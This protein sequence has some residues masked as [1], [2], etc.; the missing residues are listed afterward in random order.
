M[1]A[2]TEPPGCGVRAPSYEAERTLP[3]SRR[4]PAPGKFGLR[5]V[6]PYLAAWAGLFGLL[7]PP[8]AHAAAGDTI[9]N[10]FSIEFSSNGS[11]TRLTVQSNRVDTVVA[12]LPTWRWTPRTGDT[13]SR[14]GDT[15]V[16]P[17]VLENGGNGQ[18]TAVFQFDTTSFSVAL[19]A[20]SALATPL[21][22]AP[23]A[24]GEARAVYVAISLPGGAPDGTS[25]TDAVG[26]VSTADPDTGSDTLSIRVTADAAPPSAPTGL[27][28]ADGETVTGTSVTF[29]WNAASDSISGVRDYRVEVATDTTFTTLL[30]DSFVTTTSLNLSLAPGR[31]AWRVRARD[32][33][34]FFSTVAETPVFEVPVPGA[35]ETLKML[36]VRP[37]FVGS[38]TT[39]LVVSLLTETGAL[40]P[41]SGD[42]VILR[43]LSSDSAPWPDSPVVATTSGGTAAFDYGD[44]ADTLLEFAI[45]VARITGE[46][47]EFPVVYAW[48]DAATNDP[49]LSYNGDSMTAVLVRES[50]LS[51]TWRIVIRQVPAALTGLV[52]RANENLAGSGLKPLAG[53]GFRPER[54]VFV[55]DAQGKRI[56]WLDTPV[57]IVLGYPESTP[58]DGTTDLGNLKESTLR[59][60]VLDEA[61]ERWTP[62]PTSRLVE[63]KARLEAERRNFSIFTILGF[64]AGDALEG[65]ISYPNPFYPDLSGG[66]VRGGVAQPG[67]VTIDLRQSVRSMRVTIYNLAGDRVRTLANPTRTAGVP[68]VDPT[69]GLA[70]WDGRNDRGASV[71]SGM[72]FYVVETDVGRFGG[73]MTVI[74]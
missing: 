51:D 70:Y 17:A 6:V 43:I 41:S 59:A 23:L 54:E 38:E 33:V 25:E 67:Y 12:L 61:S 31:Y 10:V 42:T 63:L 9:S 56:P 73:R 50:A 24:A 69:G 64:G 37:E 7:T 58:G 44:R 11:A 40:I 32:A 19:F 35:G 8:C 72:Y 52:D 65:A 27:T 30:A 45:E 1:P 29:S 48:I 3:T 71:A 5:R 47:V 55:E 4:T 16:F 14:V 57:R 60:Y 22:S 20:D 39:R 26:A 62:V 49:M 21:D 15:V 28:P 74:R 66:V 18:D 68:G 13:F 34:E 53:D 36:R 46:T 2:R